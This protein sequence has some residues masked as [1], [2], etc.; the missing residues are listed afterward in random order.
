MRA[1][2]AMGRA[3][4]KRVA[5][6]IE[7]QAHVEDAIRAGRPLDAED[8]QH[9]KEGFIARVLEVDRRTARRIANYED[10]KRLHLTPAQ[11]AGAESLQGLTVDFVP[12]GFLDLARAASRSV[13]RVATRDG[14]ALGTGFKVSPHLFV[15]NHHVVPDASLLDEIALEFNYE[16][17]P[18][19]GALPIS[20]FGLD[21]RF[22]RH[23]PTADLD[24][25]LLLI[26]D[27]IDG[28]GSIDDFGFL[29]L[30][31][32]DDKHVMAQ[33]VNIIQHPR[34]RPKEL[35][36]RENRIVA[37]T[38]TT[39]I[40]GADTLP[41]SSGSPVFNDNFEVIGIHHWGSPHR[42]RRDSETLRLPTV[43]NE[44]IRISA[45]LA[46]LHVQISQ[47][48]VAHRR[49]VQAALSPS[50]RHPSLL[51]TMSSRSRTA[52]ERMPESSQGGRRRG[53]GQRAS[54]IVPIEISVAIPAGMGEEDRSD[55]TVLRAD[56][57]E[58]RT[59]RP[60]GA[61]R[62]DKPEPDYSKRKGYKPGF[63]GVRV[64]L[65]K[66]TNP[67]R[68]AINGDREGKP[69]QH[70]LRYHHF[71][72]LVDKT[73]RIAALTAV[74][75]NGAAVVQINRKTNK[76]TRI[77]DPDAEG[78]EGYE[79]W[80]L[81]ARI[82]E[83][84]QST[85]D[86][87]DHDELSDFQ[88]GHLVK[89]TDPMW[90]SVDSARR[91][92]ADTFHF[93]NCAPQHEEFNPRAARW[94]GLENWIT[95]VSDDEDL[96]VSVFTGPILRPNDPRVG[97]LRVP[98]RY[99]KVVAWSEEGTLHARAAVADQGPLLRARQEGTSRE[100]FD[101]LPDRLVDVRFVPIGELG[102]MAGFDFGVLAE[103]DDYDAGE[104]LSGA[105]GAA[106][107]EA[108]GGFTTSVPIPEGLAHE[109]DGVGP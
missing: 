51:A 55:V 16:D 21:P 108:W 61:E 81:D 70:E 63:L 100:S 56:R 75:I 96:L 8:D 62:A 94:A 91:G 77:E 43:G 40:Y 103:H 25:A 95:K 12:I 31:S 98:R 4:A 76:V 6:T 84:H 87:Y 38:T 28:P 83:E 47:M 20:R 35:V 54:W 10:P 88:R 58:P 19:L 32:T 68:L 9:R 49:L 64:P 109:D 107:A 30:L 78:A 79:P 1:S 37:R 27:R 92:Q 17:S 82:P 80:Y 13:A 41:G 11:Q 66:P 46:E 34:G 39:L 57:G 71:S 36:C 23:D 74:N 45:V 101:E 52:G 15:T 5:S 60:A 50:F 73:R 97:E 24:F 29:P 2:V 69:D 44:A 48:E 53:A 90:G 22:Y 26:G 7:E 59:E 33:F 65:P 42:A 3:V 93:T 67:E 72:V 102:E 86:D 104:S 14:Q 89:R 85:Q 18:Q 99:W 105:E 106:R